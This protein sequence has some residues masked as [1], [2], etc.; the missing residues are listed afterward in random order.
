MALT[1]EQRILADKL[2][3]EIKRFTVGNRISDDVKLDAETKDFLNS[4]LQG[5]PEFAPIFGKPQHSMQKY[6]LDVHI[7][8]VL[9]DSVNDPLYNQLGDTDKIVL[10]FSTLL[11]DIGKRYLVDGSDTGHAAKSAEYV[12]SILDRFN[13]EPEIKDRIIS[14][15]SNHHWFK[16]YCL[17]N[18]SKLDIATLCRRPQD[19]LIYQIMAKAD[20]KNVNDKFYLDKT[21]ASSFAEAEKN[22][23]AKMA[24]IQ[25]AVDELASKQVVITA[26]RFVEVP[27]RVTST[28]RVL[29]ARGFPVET[30]KIKDTDTGLKTLNLTKLNEDTD[31]FN[32]GFNHIPLKDLRLTVHMVNQS[33]NLDVFKTLARNPM[34]NSAQS[35]SMISMADKS[36][37]SGLQFGLVLDVDNANVSHAYFS[38]TSSGTKKG[39]AH[40]VEEMFENSKYRTYVKDNFKSYLTEKGVEISDEEY[41]KIIKYIQSKKYPETQIKNLKVGNRTFTRED[42]LGA[43][44]Y[45]RDQLIEVKKMKTHGEHNEI[46]A[47]N[48]K[49]KGLIAKVNSLD[50]CPEWF[51]EF[52]KGNNLPII[53]I[54]T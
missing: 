50:E 25:P 24:E 53:L 51:L 42:I 13:F 40:F 22:F 52:A 48:S 8:K 41:T 26:S 3:E 32:Y 31:M 29:P 19:F 11:H 45:S 38:N 54:G 21:G 6:S 30:V 1:P 5:V 27:Q 18:T 7:L 9:Q 33:I 47:L 4:I 34:N 10:K 2:I 35:I 36:T 16:E 37:Y 28:G 15:V 12:Y 39:F 43:F 44:T 46:V 23:A 17:G 49:V 14:V 20:L